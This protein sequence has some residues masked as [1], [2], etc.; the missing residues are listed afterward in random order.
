VILIALLLSAS[1]AKAEPAVAFAL[2]YPDMIAE[3]LVYDTA[4]ARF[5]VSSVHRGGVDAVGADGK[6]TAFVASGANDSWGMFGI[7]LDERRGLLWVTTAAMPIAAHS[8]ASDKGRSALLEYDLRTG[9]FHNRY[10]P[11]DEGEHAFGDL[12]VGAD[13]TVY[14]S[15]GI[16]SGVYMLPAGANSLRVLVPRGV[17]KSPQTPALSADGKT[18]L[19]P[20]YDTGIT[21]VSLSNGKT[22]P[23]A[24]PADLEL[25]GIDGMVR[26]G[27]ELFAVQNG[28]IPNR[29]MKL[30]LDT[31]Q[32]R[33]LHGEPVARKGIAAELT[34]A[35]AVGPWLYFIV[36]SGWDRV[37]DDGTIKPGTAGTAPAVA[38]LPIS[39]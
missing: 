9:A 29:I 5:L 30:T 4:G 22:R 16:G 11:P 24:H 31:A 38:K 17:L 14:V 19:V 15:D 7:A 28:V 10:L 2:P 3:D 13:G 21:A 37:Q 26:V 1:A 36:R 32:T 23:L 20:D 33:I 8:Q 39:R 34:H 12:T 6:V 35:T 18:L 25:R 27:N